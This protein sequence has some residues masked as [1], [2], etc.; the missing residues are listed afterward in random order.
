MDYRE[1]LNLPATN[2]KMKANLT[3]KEPAYLKK[4]QKDDLY[5]QVQEAT[6]QRPL[7]ILH[8]GP[9]YANGHLHMGHAFNKILKDIILKSRRMAGF[10]A[11]FVPGWDCHGLP[12]ELNVDK[13]M[14]AKKKEV[15]K[16]SFRAACRK[17]AEKWVKTQK[18]EF[19]R[20][21]VLADWD[22]PYLTIHYSYEAAIAR[23]FNRF[24]MNGSVVRSKKPVYWCSSCV[25]ALAEAEVEYDDHTS[26]SIYVKF[27]VEQDLGDL[28]PE[29]AGKK[30]SVVIW[31]TTPWTLPANMG[32]ALHPQFDYAAVEVNGEVLIMAQALVEKAM[33]VFGLEEYRELAVFSGRLLEGR[34]C[35][36]PFL[37]RHSQI[38]LADYVTLETG[39][40]CVHTAPGHG[41][42]D[43]I[44]GLNY[45]LE[46]LSPVDDQG[47]FTEE[48]GAYAGMHIRDANLLICEDLAA[49]GHLLAQKEMSHSYPHCWRCRKPVI[50]RATEQWF[51]GMESNQLRDKALAA[52]K[53]VA[54]TP[55]WGMERIHGMVENRPDWCLSRQRAWGVPITAILCEK[56]GQIMNT[57]QVNDRID[58]LFRQ[59]GADAWFIHDVSIFLGKDAVCGSCGSTEFKKEEDIL[60]VWFDSGVSYAAVLEERGLPT[61]ADLY[62]EGSDQHR[63]WFQSS[64]LASVGTRG[65]APYKSV[66]THG[67]V[68]DKNGR[69]MSKSVG[70]VIAPEEIIKEYGAE[71]LRLWVSSEDYSD[72]IKISKEM[73]KQLAD[74][75]RKIRNTIRYLLSNLGD[76]NPATDTV[77]FAEME[78]LDCWALA[79]YERMKRRVRNGYDA[80]EFHHVFHGL[81]Q[82]CTVTMSN[83]YLDILKDRL[84]SELPASRLRRSAQTVLYE[85]LV[86]MLKLMAPV[87]TFTAV[88]SWEYLPADADR[89]ENIFIALFPE[90]ND[91]Y[92]QDELHATWKRLQEVR[93]EITRV[94]EAARRDK[95]IG[96]PLEAEVV[97]TAGPEL[98]AFLADKWQT[99]E[100]ISNVSVLT[101]AEVP[102]VGAVACQEVDGLHLLVRP[103][104]G[105]KCERCWTRSTTVGADGAHPTLCS[106]CLGVINELV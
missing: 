75:Y 87:A 1:T 82:F 66:L 38:V 84:Y 72:E 73:L 57:D 31:T 50:F 93:G 12:I 99:L 25:T 30:S 10:H 89:E 100:R 90:E 77:A 44:T 19:Q 48:A 60:D 94:L 98:V 69:K 14:G 46:V 79:Q 6:R 36:H 37:A 9:P 26:H 39:T 63:G 53:E 86:G 49:S 23:E 34:R 91:A 21:G 101:R 54:W 18:A 8:D 40:G 3:Q 52:I 65:T 11:P 68:V 47:V 35:R 64:L 27:E 76:F 85:I 17:Y 59:E 62:L 41:R 97:L 78:E 15:P 104:S 74:A 20:F 43:Y 96:H 56:C 58:E 2:F 88:E 92:L 55:S 45:D 7:Y 22:N 106:R 13:E 105:D 28:I 95:V 42:E 51:I 61:P 16:L 70:N 33:A 24:L 80:Y 5:A 32:V 67:F 83:F 103:A 29:L 4:W 71:I 102:P 81:H